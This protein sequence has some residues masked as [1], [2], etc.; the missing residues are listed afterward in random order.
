VSEQNKIPLLPGVSS[1]VEQGGFGTLGPDYH[2][3]G[4][5]SAK[6]VDQVMKGKRA[7]A[8]PVATATRYQYFFNIRSARATGVDIPA[9]LIRQ[10]AKVYQ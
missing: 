8:I 9:D 6:L 2:D 7:G 1:N 4:V 10:A 3:I 5:Q